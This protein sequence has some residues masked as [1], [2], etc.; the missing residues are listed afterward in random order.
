MFSRKII[1]IL[2]LAVAIFAAAILNSPTILASTQPVFSTCI[3]P[4]GSV[5]ADYPNGDHGV[6]GNQSAFQGHDIVYNQGEG[7]ALQ[8]LC[9]GNTGIQTEWL[10]ASQ[11]ST[12]DIQ[13]LISQ[14]WV[15]IPNGLGWGL[16]DSAYLALNS[17]YSCG[18]GST[19][20]SSTSNNSS[21][22]SSNGTG[23]GDPE[24][25]GLATTGNL[26][27]IAITTVLAGVFFGLFLI[28]RRGKHA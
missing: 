19:Q 23:G 2:F 17:A 3:A 22:D 14:G 12:E 20:G 8:C 26:G 27:N 7:N 9:T 28:V 25:L 18:G 15:Y 13:N 21:N 4:S 1:S 10:N 5:M 24:V 11:L 16:S 6:A